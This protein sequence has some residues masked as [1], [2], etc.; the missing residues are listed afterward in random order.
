MCRACK[1]RNDLHCHHVVFR[2]HAGHDLSSNLLTVCTDCHKKIHGTGGPQH[3]FILAKSG[4]PDEVPNADEGIKVVVLNKYNG[5][6]PKKQ[7]CK[8]EVTSIEVVK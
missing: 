2:S 8:P 1:N 5:K 4:D 6:P 7:K 3:I